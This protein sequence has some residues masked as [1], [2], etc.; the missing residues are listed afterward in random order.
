M[1]SSNTSRRAVLKGL[2]AVAGASTILPILANEAFAEAIAFP[3]AP[4]AENPFGLAGNTTVEGV[5]FQ[6]GYGIDYINRGADL[7]KGLHPGTQMSVSGVQGIG[8]RLRPRFIAGN[9]PDVVGNNGAGSLDPAT[10]RLENQMADLSDLMAA[11]AINS[12]GKTVA[13]TLFPGSQ[14]AGVDEDRQLSVDPIY[15]ICGIWYDQALFDKNGW[16]YP[17]TWSQMLD[18]CETIKSAGLMPWA[19]GGRNAGNYVT[20]CITYPLIHKLAGPQAV[21]NIRTATEGAWLA[22]EVLEAVTMTAELGKAGFVMP[23]SEALTHTE[24]QTEWLLGNAVFYA[25]G[26]W[27]ENEMRDVIPDGYKLTMSPIPGKTEDQFASVV[28]GGSG[29]YFVPSAAH[30]IVGGKEYLRCLFSR[31]TAKFFAESAGVIMPILNVEGLEVSSAVASA[32]AAV[33]AAGDEIVP[34]DISF[35]SILEAWNKLT[36]ELMTAR[37]T[38]QDYVAQLETVSN[39]AREA[40]Y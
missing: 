27:L 26:S 28:A 32:M 7:L 18:L 3:I 13:E 17:R 29:M 14:I 9:P 35:G 38:P 2:A 22:P 20:R 23:G 30:N 39:A 5:F 10:L 1:S 34:L 25:G 15:T 31:S 8:D 19:Y 12:P 24:A 37:M 36:P 16:A 33:T 4:G 40:A 21:A 11:P 6:G